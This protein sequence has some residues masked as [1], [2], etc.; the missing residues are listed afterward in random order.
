M[1]YKMT[2]RTKINILLFAALGF[3]VVCLFNQHSRAK[4]AQEEFTLRMGYPLLVPL[5]E[6]KSESGVA[7]D[8]AIKVHHELLS[9]CIEATE[10]RRPPLPLRLF[11]F[12]SKTINFKELKRLENELGKPL[13]DEEG[14]LLHGEEKNEEARRR[15][16]KLKKPATE[17][18]VEL[19]QLLT[20]QIMPSR[21]KKI[22]AGLREDVDKVLKESQDKVELYISGIEKNIEL[23]KSV[24]HSALVCH[25]NRKAAS[26]SFLTSYMYEDFFFVTKEM[27]IR[28]RED[29]D[30][31]IHYN[32][33]LCK[34]L[35]SSEDK[36]NKADIKRLG[37]YTQ[38][39]LRRLD[40]VQAIIDDDMQKAQELLLAAMKKAISEEKN[41]V[42]VH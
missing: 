11:S 13:K 8:T 24:E 16:E 18:L 5:I 4:M 20:K 15:I 12:S 25:E 32:N 35:S 36:G 7:Y 14:K 23:K 1:A 9:Q 31:T 21:R 34:S 33:I 19:Q 37:S 29:I 39:E 40:L 3:L 10:D 42:E 28:F 26:L 2:Y 22:P 6:L 38:S 30:Q 17:L 41:L 27:L